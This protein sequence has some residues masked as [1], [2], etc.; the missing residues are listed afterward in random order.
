MKLITLTRGYYAQ[1]DDADFERVNQFFW[2]CHVTGSGAC[3][4]QRLIGVGKNRVVSLMHRFVLDAPEGTMLDHR[5][6]NGL[7]NQRSNL[8]LCPS[9]TLNNANHPVRRDSRTGYKGVA[10]LLHGRHKNRI[11]QAR[12]KA[13]GRFYFLGNY[14]TPEEAAHAYDAKAKEIFGEY[15]RLNFSPA[16]NEP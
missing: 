2:Q 16:T 9:H 7:N 13:Y 1:V 15:A 5:D 6:G 14:A 4:A 12:L 8:R 11:F 3:Y 10:L